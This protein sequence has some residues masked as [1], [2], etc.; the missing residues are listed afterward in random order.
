M[1]VS[2]HLLGWLLLARI[3]LDYYS[4]ALTINPIQEVTQRLG[5]LAAYFLIASLAATPLHTLFGWREMLKRRRALGLYAFM[6]A[7]LHALMFIGVDYGF[8]LGELNTILLKKPYALMGMTTFFILLPLAIT[9]FKWFMKKMGRGWINLHRLVY[10][11]ALV[12][13]IHFAWAKKGNLLALS[14]D[15]LQPLLLG[16]LVVLLL[17]LRIPPVRR[18]ASGFRQKFSRQR[19]ILKK[20]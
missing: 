16:I 18:W 14:G 17:V 1:Q 20:T 5:R 3:V 15:I 8:N 11:A 13:I 4:N 6:Y 7:S 19:R 12:D 10:L 9:S 2:I